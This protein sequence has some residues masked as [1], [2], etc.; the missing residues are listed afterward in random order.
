LRVNRRW[1]DEVVVQHGVCPFA[2]PSL[3]ADGQVQRRVLG[4]LDDAR[5]A[6]DA[7]AA[8]ARLAVGLLI[9]PRLTLDAEAFDRA[10]VPLRTAHSAFVAAVFHPATPFTTATAAQAVGFF[11][12]APDPTLQLVRAQALDDVRGGKDVA[13]KFLFDYSAA[14]WQELERRQNRLPLSERIARDNHRLLTEKI[15]LLQ[16]IYDDIRVDRD[17][18]YARVSGG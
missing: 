6:I 9:F 13:G 4:S 12:R 14:A 2:A 1:I 15:V 18:S 3:A 17:Q 7:L 5:A 10:C 16:S 11:R 8:D